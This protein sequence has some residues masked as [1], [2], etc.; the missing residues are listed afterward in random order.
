MRDC[1]LT[2]AMMRSV[3]ATPMSAEI[4]SSSSAS[5]VSTSTGRERRSGR[6]GAADDLVE[7]LDDLL[8]GAREALADPAEDSHGIQMTR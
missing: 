4:S 8:F 1:V 2:A 7:A 5:T 3:A 6:V